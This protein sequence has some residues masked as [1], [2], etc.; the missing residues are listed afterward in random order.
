MVQTQLLIGLTIAVLVT[1]GA[2][3]IAAENQLDDSGSVLDESDSGDSSG[4]SSSESDSTADDSV[5][6]STSSF[7]SGS[8]GGEVTLQPDTLAP[9]WTAPPVVVDGVKMFGQCGGVFYS[10]TTTCAD[11]DAYCKQLSIYSSIC[12]P[13]PTL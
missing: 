6:A 2:Q 8:S 9:S 4:F 5:D 7:G 13:K 11:P 12:S 3:E 10:G 1:V